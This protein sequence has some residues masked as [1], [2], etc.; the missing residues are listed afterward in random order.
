MIYL[1][2]VIILAVVVFGASKQ[3]SSP[4]KD[5]KESIKPLELD[6]YK[7]TILMSD[8]EIEFFNRLIK[9]FPEYYVFPQVAM[10][11]LVAPKTT[12]FKKMNSIK[13]TYNRS[14][15]DFVIYKDKKVFAVIELDDKTHK[16][17]ED[18]DNKRDSILNQ[19]GYKTFRFDSKNKPSVEQLKNILK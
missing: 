18:K 9:A 11:G 12:D 10:S 13:N 14:R 3:K 19:A 2:L 4:D 5:N 6:S 17:K 8:N 1:I 7:S 15:V 16:G